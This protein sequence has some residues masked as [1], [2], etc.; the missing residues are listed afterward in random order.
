MA[1]KVVLGGKWVWRRDVHL[2]QGTSDTGKAKRHPQLL[3]WHKETP[4]EQDT[5]ET[6]VTRSAFS[7]QAETSG[8][9]KHFI[10]RSVLKSPHLILRTK[11]PI[12]T[13]TLNTTTHTCWGRRKCPWERPL[14]QRSTVAQRSLVS[15][16]KDELR[17]THIALLLIQAHLNEASLIS[18][19]MD[20]AS[21]KLPFF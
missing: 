4:E 1:P 15:P 19:K 5:F 7:G 18:T 12:P 13:Q 21:P 10:P 2:V 8:D 9:K 3:W 17:V 6:P 14:G 16:V 20:L 11:E